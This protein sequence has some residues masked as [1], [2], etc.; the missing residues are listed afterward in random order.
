MRDLPSPVEFGL[1][2]FVDWMRGAAA[3]A[4]VGPFASDTPQIVVVDLDGGA[5]EMPWPLQMIPCVLV[6]RTRRPE[7]IAPAAAAL[8]DVVICENDDG[9][10][11][12]RVVASGLKAEECLSQI[13]QTVAQNPVA[14]TAFALLLRNFAAASVA[15]GLV[16]ESITYAALQGAAEYASWRRKH[17]IR[18]VNDAEQPRVLSRRDGDRFEITLFRPD[19]HNAFDTLMRDALT[20]ALEEA[21]A[22]G[23]RHITIRGEGRSFCSGGDL[24]EFGTAPDPA[25][26][27]LIRMAANTSRMLVGLASRLEAQLHGSCV[28]SGLEMAAFASTVSARRDSRFLLPEIG[29]GLI[30]G[31][32]GSVS[33]RQRIGRHRTAYL[34]LSGVWLDVDTALQWGLVDRITD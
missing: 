16:A 28:G 33:I 14:A 4:E 26:A 6:G 8:V 12:A 31:A 27:H 13:Q 9:M 20:S 19:R 21:A 10:S 1:R 11:D 22:S 32:G 5:V 34:G 7:R 23:A 30:P 29:M 3:A 18:A 25:V 15:D 2:D 17:P 24:D